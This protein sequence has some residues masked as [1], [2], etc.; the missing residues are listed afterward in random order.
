MQSKYNDTMY[1]NKYIT[2]RCCEC[3]TCAFA[4]Y[5]RTTLPC[6]LRRARL[7]SFSISWGGYLDIADDTMGKKANLFL[8][9]RAE[10]GDALLLCLALGRDLGVLCL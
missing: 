3:A 10:L 7:R 4:A 6:C 8:V 5:L 9:G 1:L 2:G